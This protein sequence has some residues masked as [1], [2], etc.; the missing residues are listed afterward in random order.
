M[1]LPNDARIDLKC[2]S[3]DK[4]AWKA[5]AEQSGRSLSNW[6]IWTLNQ[7]IEAAEKKSE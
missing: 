4:E 3:S 7:A 2:Q 5:A 1:N 6:I